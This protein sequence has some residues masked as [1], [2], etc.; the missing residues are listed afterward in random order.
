M[1]RFDGLPRDVFIGVIA[2]RLSVA[3]LRRAGTTPRTETFRDLRPC[4]RFATRGMKRSSSS[5]HLATALAAAFVWNTC[6]TDRDAKQRTCAS[7]DDERRRRRYRARSTRVDEAAEAEQQ[8]NAVKLS[9]QEAKS[10]RAPSA[11]ARRRRAR[12]IEGRLDAQRQH[13]AHAPEQKHGSSFG[14]GQRFVG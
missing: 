9:D 7:G 3:F 11:S 14:V 4:T 13:A 5:R 2:Q 8:A 12:S 1:E 6:S 10:R